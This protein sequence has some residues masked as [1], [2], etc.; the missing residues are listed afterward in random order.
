MHA[1]IR[2]LREILSPPFRKPPPET[3]RG[4]PDGYTLTT[5]S[6]GHSK[7]QWLTGSSSENQSD[8]PG[9]T[10]INSAFAVALFD[11]IDGQDETG[12]ADATDDDANRFHFLWKGIASDHIAN[13]KITNII[14]KILLKIWSS[15]RR[16]RQFP[17]VHG[18]MG[19]QANSELVPS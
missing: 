18:Q 19:W 15:T 11:K 14:I 6:A 8:T 9:A 5:Q 16:R 4:P 1:G 12:A 13:L 2:L 10:Y 17:S 3:M 7:F